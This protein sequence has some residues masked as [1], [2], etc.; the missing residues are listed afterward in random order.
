MV[1]AIISY[2][3]AKTTINFSEYIFSSLQ[4]AVIKCSNLMSQLKYESAK[5]NKSQQSATN[6]TQITEKIV[7][8][9]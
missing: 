3:T 9:K 4:F 7:V 2:Y 6:S 8:Q 5:K 1:F